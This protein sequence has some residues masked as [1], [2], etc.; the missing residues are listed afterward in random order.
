M[1]ASTE[2]MS[3][4][5]N[6]RVNE[7]LRAHLEEGK[8][9]AEMHGCA[10]P[11]ETGDGLMC[12]FSDA[13]AAIEFA[14]EVL[15][16]DAAKEVLDKPEIGIRLG[17]ESGEVDVSETDIRGLAANAA[18]RIQSLAVRGGLAV[19]ERY[20]ASLAV[21][22]GEDAVKAVTMKKRTA[23][24]QGLG[25]VEV[26]DIDWRAVDRRECVSGR[27]ALDAIK[28][29][30][31]PRHT[32][33]A[34]V[35]ARGGC[36]LWPVVPRDAV[37]VIH[38]AQLEIIRLLCRYGDWRPVLLIADCGGFDVN[39]TS[40]ARFG[41]M[42]VAEARRVGIRLSPPELM[43]AWFAGEGS[44]AE[45]LRAE[46]QNLSRQLEV[47]QLRSFIDKNYGP[48]ERA[49]FLTYSVMDVLRPVLT[50]AAVVHFARERS[51]AD[52]PTYVIVL[53]GEDEYGQWNKIRTI[54]EAEVRFGAIFNGIL[55]TQ[56]G[57]DVRQKDRLPLWGDEDACVREAGQ[58][59]QLRWL[60][61]HFLSIVR[62]PMMPRVG[63]RELDLKD[64]QEGAPEP[65]NGIEARELVSAVWDKVRPAT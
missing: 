23:A 7:L 8:C 14:V 63:G 56:D 48:E 64:W 27:R 12:W 31:L 38:K 58:G 18:Q 32:V 47:N 45:G 9:L 62:Y 44:R 6:A 40:A 39:V 4:F 3:Q 13:V 29:A 60:A 10:T 21:S 57:Y 17:I 22:W 16:S 5:G 37:T 42:V 34:E 59:N 11:K 15:R 1:V 35:L 65:P 43:S 36:V 54:Y 50:A 2:A 28:R 25:D 19:G 41:R 30:G 26:F 51:N 20:R 24:A 52:E 61:Q 46:F 49:K 33:E 53:V 55:R